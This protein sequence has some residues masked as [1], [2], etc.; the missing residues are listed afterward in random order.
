VVPRILPTQG[1]AAMSTRNPLLLATAVFMATFLLQE[2]YRQ[3]AKTPHGDAWELIKEL[4][5]PE[6][7]PLQT[8]GPG[9]T[10]PDET[11]YS[12]R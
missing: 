7:P 4:R 6:K 8:P 2:I 3:A 5:G 12:P 10:N 1:A 11:P 9:W